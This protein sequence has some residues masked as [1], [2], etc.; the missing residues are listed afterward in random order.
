MWQPYASLLFVAEPAYQKEHETRGRR[1]PAKYQGCRIAIQ[2]GLSLPP[3]VPSA[4]EELARDAFGGDWRRSLPRGAYIGTV[5]LSGCHPTENLSW[6]IGHADRVAGIWDPGRYAWALSDRR[7][8][9]PPVPAKG[10]QGWW[11]VNASILT[12]DE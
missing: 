1:Y 2:A 4:L 11:K 6:H 10:K 5:V 9:V 12:G 8:I 7:A 3:C